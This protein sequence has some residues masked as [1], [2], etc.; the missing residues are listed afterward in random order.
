M[1]YAILKPSLRTVAAHIYVPC[2]NK[3]LPTL[4]ST[5]CVGYCS[6]LNMGS[7]VPNHNFP[8]TGSN[9]FRTTTTSSSTTFLTANFKQMVKT[10]WTTFFLHEPNA[11]HNVKAWLKRAAADRGV[12]CL[13]DTNV[14]SHANTIAPLLLCH[15]Y[16][17]GLGCEVSKCSKLNF[18]D[19]FECK[20]DA[21]F[22]LTL[23]C[24]RTLCTYAIKVR[25]RSGAPRLP[26][27]LTE[28]KSTR[29]K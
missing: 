2:W 22:W 20:Y 12:H 19:P 24:E 4:L 16:G 1:L 26:F 10:A 8:L 17:V 6:H 18:L 15:Q 23:Q 21:E 14:S 7:V 29:D 28:N 3:P 9:V 25:M 11:H 13:A 27:S 5:Y